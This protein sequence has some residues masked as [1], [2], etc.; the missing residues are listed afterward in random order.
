MMVQIH[1]NIDKIFNQCDVLCKMYV[2]QMHLVDYIR[3][4][5]PFY[6]ISLT[7]AEW[8]ER[9]FCDLDETDLII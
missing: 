2:I 9:R 3:L 4:I 6:V 8:L 5:G 1:V 7:V